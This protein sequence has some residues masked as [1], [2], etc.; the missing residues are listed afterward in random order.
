METVIGVQNL[1][2]YA[3]CSKAGGGGGVFGVGRSLRGSGSARSSERIHVRNRVPLS[4]VDGLRL[5]SSSSA[6]KLATTPSR[7]SSAAGTDRY[8]VRCETGTK[9]KVS[10]RLDHQVQF[11]EHHALMGSAECT[12]SWQRRVDMRWSDSGWIADLEANPG[13]N[14]EFKFIIVAGDG[15]L[16]WENGPNRFLQVPSDSGAYEVV[17][18]WDNTSEEVKLLG[19]SNGNG[20]AVHAQETED[21]SGKQQGEVNGTARAEE[22]K[23][24]PASSFV[25]EWQGRE[26]NFMRSNEHSREKSGKWDTTGLDG[27][28][29][30]LVEGDKNAANWWRKL[31]VAR[32]LLT[33]DVGRSQ[34][35]ESLINISV[36]LKWIN[37]G[38]LQ[39]YEDGGHHRPNRHAEI[40]RE[41]F[42]EIERI[43]AAK[44]FSPKESLVVRKIHPSLP[45]FKAEFTASVPL[46][47]IRDIAHRNDIPHDLKQEIKHTIQNK[48]HRNA[49]PEDLVATE[50][51]LARVTQTPGQYS[52]AFVEQ[53]QIFYREL[54]DF[55]NAGSLTEQLE[56]LR[57]SLDE[58]Q[59]SVLDT[60]LNNKT[61]LDQT[62]S[63]GQASDLLI[64]ALHSLTGLRAV[65][66][67][68]LESGLRND[69]SDESI[70]MRQ[71]WRLSEIGLED[72]A[73]VLLSRYI[74]ELESAGG[75]KPLIDE[76]KSQKVT[77]WNHPLGVVVLGVRQLGLSGWQQ[78][79][80]LAIE[81]ELSAWQEAGIQAREGPQEDIKSW[82]LRIKA[83]LDRTRRLAE[84]YT[85]S[86]LQLFPERAEKLG[87]AFGIPENSVRTFTEA[88][89]R[90]SVVFQISKLCS[91][92]L[93][94]VRDVSGSEGWDALMPG[95]ATGTL[96]EVDRIVPGSIPSSSKGPVILLVKEADGDEEVK[97]A[98]ENV[99]GVI[100]QHELPHLSHLGVRARQEKVVFV[101][102]DA[103]DKVSDLRKLIGKSV[104]LEASSEGAS[105]SQF[106]GKQQ[107]TENKKTSSAP[108]PE[109]KVQSSKVKKSPKGAVLELT[110]SDVEK[111]GA[112]AAACGELAK[113]AEISKKVTSEQ[114]VPA[115][116]LVPQGLVIPFGAMDDAIERSGLTK[117]FQSLVE[118]TQTA[119]VEDG[120]LD[121]ICNKLRE[122]VGSVRPEAK[123]LDTLK[124]SFSPDS[125]LIVRSSANVEDL[126]GMSGA[127]LYES[128]PNVNPAS[129][130][131]NFGKAV[132]EVWA[133]LYTRRAVLSRR[134]AGVPQ[135]E[136]AMAVLVQELISPDLSFVLHT[137]SPIDKDKNVVQAEIASGLGETLA[138]GTRGSPWRLAANKFTG[139]VKTL[140]FAN[141]SEELI[142][143]AGEKTADGKM[144]KQVA[145][146]S[147]KALSVDDSYRKQ[148][149][150]YLATIGFFLEQKF[151]TPQD[152]EGCIVGK[153]IYIVQARPQP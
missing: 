30:I 121:G 37:T 13:E 97:A 59:S 63:G 25:Q 65:L 82:A 15:Q 125:K 24:V 3:E 17:T 48:L 60:F 89:I 56:G 139:G 58:Q 143:R 138:S 127:G 101:T 16:I 9:V 126:A 146:Y 72:Y 32:D 40:S 74:N 86:L 76:A 2:N 14:L 28:A 57:A 36:Y 119:K 104:K 35:L 75:A 29:K 12:G 55:F 106:D 145:D 50:A 45:A 19:S 93:K 10:V 95:I 111:A 80:C 73:F 8:S 5:T 46:T 49:G 142:V 123:V 69:A 43:T 153:N 79:E 110:G 31:E 39:C 136:A 34:R 128:I 108:V 68:G 84:S 67:K 131:E 122:L 132:A 137:V 120:E 85:D 87:K 47:R 105:V 107:S 90:A 135:K 91:L 64:G 141:F 21:K 114:G 41:I 88:E 61:S 54:K 103:E 117:E 1:T 22:D 115:T 102:C 33:G 92:L 11:G 112:K 100:L 124:K 23:G 27:P 116:F 152:V 53:L 70:A 78:K 81:N 148:I 7:T 66:V 18:Q 134:I 149:G 20:S 140:A 147:T 51:M 130:P 71:K 133:S 150:Q 129:D 4:R 118:K 52:G 83:T 98:G 26:I 151:G 113:L 77:S 42:R 62:S 144:V 96:V 99:M 94:A 6:L 44:E 38:Q 109:P